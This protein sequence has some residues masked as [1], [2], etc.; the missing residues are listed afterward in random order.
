MSIS[1]RRKAREL[2]LQTLYQGE[3]S[4]QGQDGALDLIRNNFSANKNALPYAAELVDGVRENLAAIN[5]LIENQSANWRLD[6]MSVI[7]RNIMRICTFELCYQDDVPATV[8]INEALEIA[9][10]FS[11][12]EAP[13]FINGILDA[14]RQGLE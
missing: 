13:L 4:A 12:D 14:I 3:L 6:R 1:I 8:A 7:D 11:T 9:K 5:E 2:A 10:R